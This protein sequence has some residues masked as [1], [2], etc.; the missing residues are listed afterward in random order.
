[1]LTAPSLIA[2]LD[3]SLAAAP[4]S[5]RHDVL[6]EPLPKRAFDLV[7]ARAVLGFLPQPAETITKMA[8]ALKPRPSREPRRGSSLPAGRS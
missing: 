5:W 3:V 8:A 2:E 4:A 6:R 1:M 7:H